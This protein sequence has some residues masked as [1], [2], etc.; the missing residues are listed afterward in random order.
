LP[1]LRPLGQ[2]WNIEM[3]AD[4]KNV[5]DNY[6]EGYHVPVGHPGLYRMFGSRYDVETQPT[7]VSRAIHWLRDKRSP[8]WSEGLYQSL[9]PV[10]QHLPEERRRSWAYYTMLPNLAFDA[11]ADQVSYFQVLPKAPG[12]CVLRGRAYGLPA[13]DGS[14]DAGRRLRA[15][16]WLNGRI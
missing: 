14:S 9:L 11:Y 1:E 16:R 15:A 4:W 5:M 10:I 13:A 7:G 2:H 3:K 12:V 8:V 6:L